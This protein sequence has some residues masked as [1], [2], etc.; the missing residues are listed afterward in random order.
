MP[1]HP[2][3]STL[4]VMLSSISLFMLTMIIT[5]SD[6]S[7]VETIIRQLD[8][9]ISTKDLG[10]LSF[11]C[12]VEVL[13]TPTGALLS[14][15]KYVMDLLSKHNMFDSKLV[16]TLLVVGTSL[17]AHDGVVLVNTTMYRQVVVDFN[18]SV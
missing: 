14:Q 5:G 10:S 17:T 3:L 13:V 16:S 18:I 12:E 7:L 6:P 2:S 4:V 8:S 9:K 11:F 1:I 15:K